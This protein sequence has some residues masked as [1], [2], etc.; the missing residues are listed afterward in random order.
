MIKEI[1]K[2]LQLKENQ[3]FKIIKPS[4][5]GIYRL[6]EDLYIQ[7]QNENNNWESCQFQLCDL[8]NGAIDIEP[9]KEIL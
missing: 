7:K 3:C 4:F 9:I 1:F 8:F 6:T 2:L 5:N